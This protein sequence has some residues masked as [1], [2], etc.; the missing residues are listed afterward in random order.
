M[1]KDTFS[2]PCA[3]LAM[4]V[5]QAIAG[6][7]DG[8]SNPYYRN[9]PGAGIQ[10]L[11]VLELEITAETVRAWEKWRTNDGRILPD[12]RSA[13]EYADNPF[14][15]ES[16]NLV[17]LATYYNP[18]T[19]GRSFGGFGMRAPLPTPVAV[20][21][22]GTFIE[23]DL[24]YPFSA[25]GKYMRMD[26]WSTD[27]DGAGSRDGSGANGRNKA[28]VYIRTDDLNNIGN[29][30]PDWVANYNGET[31]SKK[32]LRLMSGTNGLWNYINI[33][34][35]TETGAL[36]NGDILFIGNIKITRP[37]PDGV[38]IPDVVDT[39]HYSVV[40]PIR[41]KY[42]RANGLF[43]IGT[44]GTGA[45]NE[46]RARHFE[47]FVDGS[48]LKAASVHPCAPRWLRE[49]TGFDFAGPAAARVIGGAEPEYVFPTDTY[50]QIRDSGK[51]GEYKSHGHVLAWYNQA[52][53]WMR[54][55]IPANLDMSWNTEGKFYAYGNDAAGPFI[56]VNRDTAR[57]VYFNHIVY[58][59]RHFMTTDAKYGSSEERGII[60]FHSFDVLNEEIH[61]SRHSILIRAN[62][63]EWKS[64]LKSISWLAAM[65]DN[66]LDDISRHYIYL[67]FKYAHIAI[68]NAVMAEKFRA[69]YNSL[70]EYMKLDGHDDNGSIDAYITEHP[71]LLTYN[72]YGIAAYTKAKMAYNM[73]KDLNTAWLSDPLYDGRPLIELMGIQG[74][75]SL[76]RTLASDNQRA[77]A[78]FASLVD[79][80]LLSGIAYSELDIK[81]NDSAP[82]GGALAPAVLNQR[83]ADALGYQY[84]LLF[85][86]FSKYAKY[87]DHVISWGR[88]GSGWQNSY[89][90]FNSESQ[91]NQG[92][93][94]VM[95]P[96]RFIKG[97][98]YLDS[99]FAGEYK[100][101]GDGYRPEL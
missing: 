34:I 86:M 28:T 39:E 78:L 90:L 82:G 43:L 84:A 11:P 24:Y 4:G 30:N 37:D 42:N 53:V 85:K 67:L 88:A 54:Q 61:E 25:A 9:D 17:K 52:P 66:E 7:A 48:N 16:G 14:D 2:L 77:V 8:G 59:L 95:N 35:N 50:M 70:P 13:F 101:V 47:I 81:I 65:S 32:H 36:V 57:R 73:I 93:Y 5:M 26:M 80:G 79:Q 62:P 22:A 6:C 27:T 18:E 45:V 100:K 38:P 83:Q 15:G 69:H 20:D 29:L 94:G 64:G 12:T 72:D 10:F 96:D 74:H 3:F 51:A 41:E 31:W 68:P 76:G 23:F 44:I 97:H 63:N 92:Y 21:T 99:Y 19:A 60:P 33:D 46:L 56:T 75:D 58:V 1:K 71:P 98:S 40:T 87:I 89:I 49:E 55:I 91:A